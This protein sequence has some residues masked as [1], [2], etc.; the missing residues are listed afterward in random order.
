MSQIDAAD[1]LVL[2]V[3]FADKAV[4]RSTLWRSTSSSL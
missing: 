4:S 2:T 3:Q 1:E